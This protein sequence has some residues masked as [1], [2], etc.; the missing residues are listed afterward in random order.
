MANILHPHVLKK[1]LVPSHYHCLTECFIHFS[2]FG[3]VSPVLILRRV[4]RGREGKFP[5]RL[6]N[7]AI[8]HQDTFME[9]HAF[10]LPLGLALQQMKWELLSFKMAGEYFRCSFSAA[11]YPILMPSRKIKKKLHLKFK[12][13]IK[14]KNGGKSSSSKK[15]P[16][17][18]RKS[19]SFLKCPMVTK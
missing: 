10:C 1:R 18:Q 13:S 5:I 14:P 9:K 16:K 3:K 11:A 17:I 2:A 7:L 4:S 8:L 19:K 15:T 6:C 12:K